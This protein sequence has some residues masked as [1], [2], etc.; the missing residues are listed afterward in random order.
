MR[1]KISYIFEALWNTTLLRERTKYSFNTCD[2]RKNS[3]EQ[4]QNSEL[5][6]NI[7]HPEKVG[8]SQ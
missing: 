2:Q 3:K 8:E 4:V 6:E 7:F 1:S 5:T